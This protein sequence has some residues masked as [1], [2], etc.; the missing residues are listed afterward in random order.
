MNDSLA[1][2]TEPKVGADG[3]QWLDVP[4]GWQQGKGAFGGF[5]L[6]SLVRAMERAHGDPS[7]RLRAM[8]ASIA[9]PVLPERSRIETKVLRAGA[10]LSAVTATLSQSES[11]CAHAIGTFAKDRALDFVGWQQRTP[12]ALGDWRERAVVDVAPPLGPVFAPH[13]EYRPARG[14]PF[15]GVEPRAEGWVR[16]KQPGAARDAAYITA[17]VD[18]WWPCAL[19]MSSGPRPMA[20]IA[21]SLE[22]VGDFHGLD[23]D[24]PCYHRAHSEVCVGGYALETRELWGHDGRLIA[25]NHQT[26]AVIK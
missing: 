7:R 16:A 15:D 21:F 12:P 8:T 3:E 1:M 13:F 24:A 6:A 14:F 5:V 9:A 19:V 20:T 18:V 25:V 11:I 4:D 2:L 10:G 23:P 26:F 22:I 17:L